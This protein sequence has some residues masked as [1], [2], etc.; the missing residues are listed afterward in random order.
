MRML[1]V[2]A[3]GL[4]GFV[5][6]ACAPEPGQP[7]LPTQPTPVAT[8]PQTPPPPPPPLSARRIELGSVIRDELR[9]GPLNAGCPSE[10]NVVIP[11]RNF[12]V[13][14]PGDGILRVEVDWVPQGGAETVALTIAGVKTTPDYSVNKKVGTHRVLAGATYGISVVYFPSHFDFIVLGPDLIGAFTLKATFER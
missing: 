4:I 6:I 11:C 14:A 3:V 8:Q 10:Q 5:A 1:Q 7:Q 13:V 12:E 9:N 2:A